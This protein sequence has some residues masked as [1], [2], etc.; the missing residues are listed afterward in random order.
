MS[1]PVLLL[2]ASEPPDG[3][4]AGLRRDMER[5]GWLSPI[6][7]LVFALLLRLFGRLDSLMLRLRAGTLLLPAPRAPATQSPVRRQSVRA[8]CARP[9]T[10]T[11]RRRGKAAP[12]RAS[13]ALRCAWPREAAATPGKPL[14]LRHARTTRAR[15]SPRRQA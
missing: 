1:N 8:P 13:R 11:S 4:A 5:Q 3:L 15:D 10:T 7:R 9:R 6:A 14:R 2:P 12:V